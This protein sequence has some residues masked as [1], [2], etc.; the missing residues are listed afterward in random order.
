MDIW[1]IWVLL[2]D[3]VQ[4]TGVWFQDGRVMEHLVERDAQEDHIELRDRQRFTE[5]EIKEKQKR[6]GENGREDEVGMFPVSV[7][8]ILNQSTL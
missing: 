1:V 2:L 3:V 5:A 4:A 6:G 7:P 8:F